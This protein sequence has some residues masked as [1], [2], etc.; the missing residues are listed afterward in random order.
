MAACSVACDAPEDGDTLRTRRGAGRLLN[1]VIV[2]VL[3]GVATG[4]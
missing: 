1:A 4:R 3:G 2:H